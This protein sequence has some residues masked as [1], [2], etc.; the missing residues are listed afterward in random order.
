MKTILSLA[1]SLIVSSVFSQI[2]I[3][4][5]DKTH[6]AICN[7]EYSYNKMVDTQ[8]FEMIGTDTVPGAIVIQVDMMMIFGLNG[9]AFIEQ[10]TET[11]GSK[12]FVTKFKD[13]TH[14]FTLQGNEVGNVDLV[15][16]YDV[17]ET[18]KCVTYFPNVTPMF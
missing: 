11:K 16:E 1:F 9:E 8:D 2:Y 6:R 13:K 12:T 15:I 7:K 4:K 14:V 3:V 18:K 17:S 10:V 5:Y